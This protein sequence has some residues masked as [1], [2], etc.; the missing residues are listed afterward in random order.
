M[1][2]KTF[3]GEG[4]IDQREANRMTSDDR[5]RRGILRFISSI[6]TEQLKKLVNAK[7]YNP[8]QAADMI[9]WTDEDKRHFEEAMDRRAVKQLFEISIKQ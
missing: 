5:L 8:E 9:Y 4:L 6:P 7:E 2:T 1:E 3:L